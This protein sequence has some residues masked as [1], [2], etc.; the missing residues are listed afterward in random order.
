[1]VGKT[2]GELGTVPPKTLP[3]PKNNWR[4]KNPV[5]PTARIL[6]TVPPMIWSTLNVI[7][8]TAWSKAINPPVRMAKNTPSVMQTAGAKPK[9]LNI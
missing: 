8:S 4:F 9:R 2:P 6:I 7:E 1:M 5:S 3:F